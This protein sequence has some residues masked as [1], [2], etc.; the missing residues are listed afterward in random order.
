MFEIMGTS[1]MSG[2]A[3]MERSYYVLVI[4]SKA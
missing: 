4:G 3:S 1:D 2:T